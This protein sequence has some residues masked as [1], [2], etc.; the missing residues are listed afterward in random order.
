MDKLDKELIEA[1]GI[2]SY[3]WN[4][5][6]LQ[7]YKKDSLHNFSVAVDNWKKAQ[8]DLQKIAKEKGHTFFT[9]TKRK[10]KWND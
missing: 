5:M 7:E 1:Y 3:W 9:D 10:A 2:L 8:N 4:E 6:N